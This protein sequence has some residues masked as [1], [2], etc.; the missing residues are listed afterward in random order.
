MVVVR[1]GANFLTCRTFNVLFPLSN[2]IIG[3]LNFGYISF[4]VSASSSFMSLVVVA[5]ASLSSDRLSSLSLMTITSCCGTATV[6]SPPVLANFLAF[7]L[8]GVF[9]LLNAS[10]SPWMSFS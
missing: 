5:V 3:V 8:S 9:D 10:T 4:L 1:F 6:L 2:L 7:T